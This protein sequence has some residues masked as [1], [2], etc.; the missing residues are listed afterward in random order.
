M[1]A[2]RRSYETTLGYSMLHCFLI[3]EPLKT[4]SVDF[5]LVVITRPNK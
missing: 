5:T 4:D 1:H 3:F 2:M